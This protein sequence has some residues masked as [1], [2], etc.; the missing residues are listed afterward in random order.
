M[1]VQLYRIFRC[2]DGYCRGVRLYWLLMLFRALRCMVITTLATPVR[3]HLVPEA[4]HCWILGG[5]LVDWKGFQCFSAWEKLHTWPLFARAMS[6][7]RNLRF[8]AA[9]IEVVLQ[10]F[11]QSVI[12]F[13][14]VMLIF[15]TPCKAISLP[16]RYLGYSS[17]DTTIRPQYSR[18]RNVQKR[19][20]DFNFLLV[21]FVQSTSFPFMFS[22]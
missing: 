9:A 12:N 11:W 8:D 3:A 22:F 17:R 4:H 7:S 16:M 10:T 19:L 1:D 13:K 20:W 6:Q 21:S 2:I 15:I 5:H 14:F 18:L